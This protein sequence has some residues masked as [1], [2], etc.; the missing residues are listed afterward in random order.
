MTDTKPAATVEVVYTETPR[1]FWNACRD[2]AATYAEAVPG[3]QAAK[4]DNARR[5]LVL[6]GTKVGTRK[7]ADQIALLWPAAV[8]SLRQQD[9][10]NRDTIREQRKT[11]EG[12]A[13][14]WANEQAYLTA[15]VASGGAL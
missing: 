5:V 2:G 8:G 14:R 6:T 10:A 4:P 7:A 13:A 3:V 1:N 11:A 15:Y 9:K 12:R